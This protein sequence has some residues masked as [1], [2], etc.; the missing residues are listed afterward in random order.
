[1]KF[2][3]LI[4][5]VLPLFASTFVFAQYQPGLMS[6]NYG[7]IYRMLQNPSSL[8]GSRYRY[9]VVIAG[10]NTVNP[11]VFRYINT[12]DFLGM[13]RLPYSSN[14]RRDL[15]SFG[16]LTNAPN[17]NAYG[18][19]IGPSLLVGFGKSHTIAVHTRLRSYL[20]GGSLPEPLTTAFRIALGARRL[21]PA[22]GPLNL[23]MR[24]ESYGE[25]GFSYGLQVFDFDLHRLKAG[26]TVRRIA[27]ARR[28]FMVAQGNYVIRT[29][30]NSTEKTLE[31]QNVSF[32]QGSTA[33]GQNFTL[34]DV[35]SGEAG[36]GWGYDLGVTYELGRRTSGRGYNS[37]TPTADPRPAYLLR[38]SASLMNGGRIAYPAGQSVSGRYASLSFDQERFE[39]FGDAPGQFLPNQGATQVRTGTIE[40]TT[41][42]LP[43]ALH[44]EADLRL[45]RSLY[46]NAISMR[47]LT[48]QVQLP[49]MLI[50]TPRFE[51]EDMEF[52]LPVTILNDKTA[53]GLS[54]RV[55]PVAFGVSDLRI[56]SKNGDNRSAQLWLGL[57]VWGWKK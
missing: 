28:Q 40:A 49:D 21:Q 33:P 7:G 52:A 2:I 34:S 43:R 19:F 5:T 9:Q 38:L 45:A 57:S 11:Y 27:G 12:D 3:R 17:H 14:L 1:M 8:G 53:V 50:L 13:V 36:S 15:R 30:P 35:F 10:N 16:S 54:L 23:D 29:T 18:E 48:S 56:F 24:Q 51:D 22:S 25:L 46:V 26:A 31:L 55:G 6:S 37:D 20:Y 41:V 39:T 32:E 47:N 4:A 42:A 44:L